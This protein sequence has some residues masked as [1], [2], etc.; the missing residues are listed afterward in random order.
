MKALINRIFGDSEAERLFQ[1]NRELRDRHFRLWD[2]FRKKTNQLLIMM[3][4]LPFRPEEMEETALLELDP[5]GTI[6]DAFAQIIE[7][8]TQLKERLKVAHD[9]I[10]AILAS[11]ATGIMV[12]D[13]SMRLLLCNKSAIDMFGLAEQTYQGKICRDVICTDGGGSTQCAFDRIMETKRAFHQADWVLGGRHFEVAG[14]PVK[15]RFGEITHVVLAYT[16][17]TRRVETEQRLREREQLYLEVFE[18]VDDII[19]CVTPD[20]SFLFVNQ[21]WKRTLGY[22]DDERAGL[23]VWNIIAPQ[24]R[25]VCLEMF[26][27]ILE[28]TPVAD[29]ETVF[30]SKDGTEIS[31]TG[32]VSCSYAH[33]K[34]LATLGVFRRNKATTAEIRIDA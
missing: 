27:Q 25:G 19:Q 2:Y 23:K 29:L 6:A 4:T 9:E 10:H 31:V 8:E 16:D 1:E 28:G 24:H 11:V 13:S 20:G 22:S 5:I 33:G 7:H 15:N 21:A 3:G 32:R 17:I 18:N 12:L 26:K 30:F 14:A 34:P